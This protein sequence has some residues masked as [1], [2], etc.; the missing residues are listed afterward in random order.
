MKVIAALA[1][2]ALAFPALVQAH[3][4]MVEPKPRSLTTMGLNID[5]TFGH[6]TNMRAAYTNGKGGECL[7]FTPNSNRPTIN[8]GSF[9]IKMRANDGANHVGP[10]KVYLVDP[11]NK[12]RKQEI[13]SMNN[14]MRS[15]HPGAGSKGTPPIPA[16]MK[17]NI[18]SNPS[19]C[20]KDHCVLQFRWEATH[21]APSIEVY[22]QCADIKIGG[23]GGSNPAPAKPAPA[24]PAPAKPAPAKPQLPV[25]AATSTSARAVTPRP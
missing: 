8:P 7:G 9:T 2:T 14:C 11:K 10:C 23:G 18:P 13:G 4:G 12:G 17:V 1:A 22:D 25:A 24:K 15:L 16:E 6:P 19:V 5:S 21:L 20:G 3:G